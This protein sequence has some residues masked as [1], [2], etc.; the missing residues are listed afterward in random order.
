MSLDT[1]GSGSTHGK[2]SVSASGSRS[3]RHRRCLT[4]AV[5]LEPAAT[6]AAARPAAAV[7]ALGRAET[8]VLDKPA[9][10]PSVALVRRLVQR[11]VAL[12]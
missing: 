8:R 1:S 9:A 2:D 10:E 6:P 12:Q 4:T 7:P 3:T 11:G 5:L